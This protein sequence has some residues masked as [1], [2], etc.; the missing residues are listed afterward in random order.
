MGVLATLALLCHGDACW[1]GSLVSAM[2]PLPFAHDSTAVNELGHT[3]LFIAAGRNNVE[4]LQL[5]CCHGGDAPGVG[6]WESSKG[7]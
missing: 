2:L 5:L 3:A 7:W 6:R 1:I 4:M